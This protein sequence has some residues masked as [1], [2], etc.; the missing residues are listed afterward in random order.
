MTDFVLELLERALNQTGA[1]I[2]G[3]HLGPGKVRTCRV[4][5]SEVHAGGEA[6]DHGRA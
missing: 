1:L 2:A 3:V 5:E 6:V 4:G